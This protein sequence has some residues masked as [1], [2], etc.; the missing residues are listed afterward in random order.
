[1]NKS[2]SYNHIELFAGCG[3]LCLGLERAGFE[4]ALANELSPMAAETFAY[5]FFNENLVKLAEDNEKPKHTFWLTSRTEELA[6]RLR[7]NP[8]EFPEFDAKKTDLP[9]DI[10]ELNGGLIVGSII[11]L[12]KLLVKDTNLLEAVKAGFGRGE[13]DLISGGPPCQSFSMAGLRKKDSDKNTLPWEFASFVSLIQPKIAVLEN[14]TGI[15]RAFKDENGDSFHAWFEVAK[16]FAVKKYVPICLHVNARLAGVAQNRPRFIMIAI[17]EDVFSNINSSITDESSEKPIF[18]NSYDFYAKVQVNPDE[19]LFGSLSYFDVMKP[20]HFKLFENSF[21]HHLVEQKEVTVKEAIDDLK[22]HSP[23]QPSEFVNKLNALFESALLPRA[24]LHNNEHRK[25][26]LTVKSR[27][28]LYQ[29]LRDVGDRSISAEI[30]AVLKGTSIELSDVSWEIIKDHEFLLLDGV[31]RKFIA[32]SELINYLLTIPTKKQ[33]QKALIASMPAPAALSIPDDGCHYDSYELRV[34][35]VREMARIQSF[36][37][38]FVF[39]SK[40]TTGGQMRKSEVPQYTQVGNAV[41]PLLGLALG[42]VIRELLELD[43]K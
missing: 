31:S 18:D 35:T 30:F 10:S 24:V 34:L 33:T 25:N 39:R 26:S 9:K 15:L 17:R 38:N 19:A 43:C 2:T 41:P 29:I 16:V 5:N 21:L 28:R 13:I 32:K 1:M 6:D 22:I 23:S 12:N 20:A 11:E 4:L 8:F 40:V 37:D 14:V 3:G 36:P 27:F 42:N 7:E